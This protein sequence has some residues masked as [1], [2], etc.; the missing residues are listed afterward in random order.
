MAS[1]LAQPLQTPLRRWLRW[2]P[3]VAILAAAIWVRWPMLPQLGYRYDTY[4][5]QAWT[6]R[7]VNGEGG[8]FAA[9]IMP[10][11]SDDPEIDHPPVGVSLLALSGKLFQDSGGDLNTKL[12]NSTNPDLVRALK[13]PSFIFDLLLII[14]GYVIVLGEAGVGWA[15]L[16]SA[17]LAFT[18][19]LLA[20]SAWWGQTDVIFTFFLV[21]TVYAL[22][23]RWTTAAWVFYALT[24]LSKFQGIPLLPLLLVLTWR[25]S[26]HRV[27]FRAVSISA[28]IFA[29]VMLPFI[30]GSGFS[31]AMRPYLEGPTKYPFVTVKAHNF[32]YWSLYSS[33][34]M[35][36]PWFKMPPDTEAT[37]GDGIYWGPISARDVGYAL[38][39]LF[40]VLISVRAWIEHERDDEFLLATG[41]FAAFFMFFTQMHERYLYPA[42]V[43][44]IFAMVKSRWLWLLWLGFAATVTYNILTIAA[45]NSPPWDAIWHAM[46]W[47]SLEN[48]RL[49]VI[50]TVILLGT[51]LAPLYRFTRLPKLNPNTQHTLL[52]VGALALVLIEIGLRL[53]PERQ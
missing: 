13:I 5:Y 42:L 43:L 34:D 39:G 48:A 31:A 45:H 16:V 9:Y 51:I 17:A 26:E 29:S 37:W 24:M 1:E 50:L 7:A 40:A 14:A 36:A 19:G 12:E 20:D 30:L 41:L 3:L 49:N 25:R 4:F 44:S 23:K 18:P 11:K 2:L 53:G 22:H 52:G 21:L 35:E 46:A 27:F 10:S 33:R 28:V 32:W 38:F 8:L 6:V 15:T 47:S